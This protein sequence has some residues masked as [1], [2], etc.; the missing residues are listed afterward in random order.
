MAEEETLKVDAHASNAKCANCGSNLK[1]DPNSGC[2][3]C[4]SCGST[5]EIKKS[6]SFENHPMKGFKEDFG[7][8]TK[9]ANSER[10]VKCDTCGANVSAKGLNM[11]T[12]CE[13]CK[14]DYVLDIKEVEGIKPDA[15]VPF[16]FGPK[17][18]AEYYQK[19]IKK[20]FFAPSAFKKKV[21]DSSVHGFYAPV[22]LFDNKTVT[23]YSGLLEQRI[24]TSD[25][26]GGTTTTYISI[27]ISGVYDLD[28]KDYVFETCSHISKNDING[29][30]PYSFEGCCDYNADML[31]GFEAESYADSLA[32]CYA[33]AKK[34]MEAVIK[35]RILSQYSYTDVKWFKASTAYDDEEFTY[36]FLPIYVLDF[37]WKNK[38]YHNYVNGQT[39]KIGRGYPK[40][41][42]KITIL[43]L[44]ILAAIAGIVVGIVFA[45]K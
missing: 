16:K 13:Y 35:Q 26:K 10:V 23:K 41:A 36:R 1:F 42:L 6:V 2:L 38:Q 45:I 7:S 28:F 44:L 5:F 15:I 34:D 32:D 22:F 43:V 25:G 9:W 11:T 18:A 27:P 19:G 12:A 39:G 31:R 14:N 24:T 33:A 37:I 17:E 30:L 8:H 20:K 29:L 40:S 4:A 21:P 3:K